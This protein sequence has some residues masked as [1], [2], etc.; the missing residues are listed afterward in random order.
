MRREGA[1]VR[2]GIGYDLHRLE[3]GR[4]LVLGSLTIDFD[5]GL[6]G[7]SD[8]DVVLHAVI[9]ALLG[10]AGL[11][12]IGEQFPDT[13]PTYKD[14]DSAELLKRAVAM[15]R[16]RGYAPANVDLVIHAEK[17]K[18]STYKEPMR[19]AIAGL[20]GR[21]TEDVNVKAKTQEGLGDIG[22]SQ[23]M[24]CTAVALIAPIDGQDQ[25]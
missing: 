10:A 16:E 4:R 14:A 12:D 23:A 15:L 20:I 17:P 2:V 18:L 3:P 7:H 25:V 6:A 1:V 8:G 9:D 21:P 13:D 5:R 19:A 22:Q 11:P 24:A